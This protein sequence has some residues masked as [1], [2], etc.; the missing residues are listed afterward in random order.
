MNLI[1]M[2]SYRIIFC[3]IIMTSETY[4]YM[5]STPTICRANKLRPNKIFTIFYGR[6]TYKKREQ[7]KNDV[8]MELHAMEWK[9]QNLNKKS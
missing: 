1:N 3:T 4:T 5:F 2:I 8:L 9:N 6:G 7:E